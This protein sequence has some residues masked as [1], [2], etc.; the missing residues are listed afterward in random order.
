MIH[1]SVLGNIVIA[2]RHFTLQLSATFSAVEQS[3]VRDLP[4][5]QMFIYIL[6]IT[7]ASYVTAKKLSSGCL[8]RESC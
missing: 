3:G 5:S 2:Q 4:M 6:H 7:D 1:Q 8:P